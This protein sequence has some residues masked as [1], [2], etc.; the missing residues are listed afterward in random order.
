PS[1]VR[2]V[3]EVLASVRGMEVEKLS[4]KIYLNVKTLFGGVE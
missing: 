3:Y 1:F 4:E 2:Y